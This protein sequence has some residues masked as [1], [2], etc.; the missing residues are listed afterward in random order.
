MHLFNAIEAQKYF[1]TSNNILVLLFYGSG[2]QDEHNV[3]KYLHLFP[4]DQ[5]IIF[6]PPKK[7][8][9]HKLNLSLIK[10]INQHHYNLVFLGYFSANLRRFVCNFN[11]EN[12]FLYDDGTY[13]IAL[14]NELYCSNSTPYL[15][16]PYSEKRRKTKLMQGVFL[17]YDFYRRCFFKFHGYKN[18]FT[19]DITL[20]FFTIFKLSSCQKEQ[21]INHSFNTIKKFF[22]NSKTQDKDFSQSVFFLGQPLNKVLSIKTNKYLYYIDQIQDFY[23]HRKLKII[24][25]THRSEEKQVIEKIK[26][27]KNLKVIT[28]DIPIEIY[29]LQNNIQIQHVASFFSSGLFTLKMLYPHSQV[30]AF[31]LNFKSDARQDIDIIYKCIQKTD[32]GMIDLDTKK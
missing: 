15:I 23:A 22:I 19:S 6:K 2:N 8:L 20:N 5:L 25:I 17:F 13:T 10:I 9:Y 4:Y 32:I 1:N 31:K 7:K 30:Q 16:K 27:Y 12:L 28:L 26:K 3:R 18:D 29:I 14:H 24:Y 21:I 11:Y